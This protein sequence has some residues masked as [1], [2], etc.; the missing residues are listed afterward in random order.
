[1]WQTG[2]PRLWRGQEAV[3]FV[4][5]LVFLLQA[6]AAA[7]LKGETLAAAVGQDR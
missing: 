4:V 3:I 1:M 6:K 5:L 7:E 2:E